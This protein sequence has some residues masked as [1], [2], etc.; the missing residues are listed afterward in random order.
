MLFS[1]Q[2]KVKDIQNLKIQIDGKY[3]DQIGNSCK[4]KYFEFVGHVL[5]ENLTWEGHAE[6]LAK[7]L[8][9][10]NFAVN[11]SKNFLPSHIRKTIY[12]S[13]FD[14]HL[15]FGNI[16]WGCAANKFLKKIDTLQKKCI[17]NVDLQ[18]YNA[19][20]EPIFKR[21]GIL[22]ISDKIA[23]NQA[24]FMHQYRN[25][26]LPTS[27]ENMFLDITDTNDLQTRNNDYNFIN[28]P[29]IKKYL[30]KYPTKVMISTWNH[31]DIDCKSTA[32]PDEFKI[33]LKHKF[34]SSY[35]SEPDCEANC[36]VCNN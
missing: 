12:F 15:N 33:L 23:Y 19:H 34:L 29:A 4:E 31:L 16:L 14:S 1:G 30:E 10:A 13:L 24:I 20:S 27:F 21:L 3:V 35:N 32:E 11:S 2:N 7:K 8:A 17:R 26:K 36:F 9:S 5:D 6:H 22:K 28:R 18:K 25:K